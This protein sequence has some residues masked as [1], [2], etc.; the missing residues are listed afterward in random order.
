MELNGTQTSTQSTTAAAEIKITSLTP[1]DIIA[2]RSATVNSA[3]ARLATMARVSHAILYT[4]GDKGMQWAVDAMPNFGV[5]RARLRIKLSH[6]SYAVVF[7]H[8]TATADQCAR[9]CA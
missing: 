4:G 7:R 9:A 8:R 2:T 6:A 3:G 1:G 5:T